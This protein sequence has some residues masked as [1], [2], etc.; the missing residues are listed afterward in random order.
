MT[1]RNLPIDYYLRIL[2]QYPITLWPDP[3]GGFTAEI[4][5]L[6]GCNTQGET[7]E[8]AVEL[9][10][11]AAKLWIEAAHETGKII[12]LPSEPLQLNRYNMN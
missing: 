4:K 5:D 7:A 12:P 10:Q 11:D 8:E 1:S 9:I 6:P 2:P 3:D